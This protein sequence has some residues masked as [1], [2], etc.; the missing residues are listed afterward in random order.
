MKLLIASDLHG[1][2]K[3]AGALLRLYETEQPDYLVLLGDFLYHGPRNDLPEDYAP[4]RVIP[5]LNIMGDKIIAVRG[6]C[7]SEVDQMMFTFPMMADYA[8][9]L[10]EDTL[11]V[12]THGHVFGPDKPMPLSK[13]A[14]LLCGH[15]HIGEEKQKQ[16]FISLN[17]GSISLPK[18]GHN[19]YMLYENR[20]FTR[21]SLNKQVLGKWSLP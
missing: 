21:Y 19:S 12:A 5:I 15:T 20:T 8:T 13:G 6:N 18:D 11:V 3:Y 17:P 10:L 7:D 4:K 1:S 9:I 16:G 2:A 14:L